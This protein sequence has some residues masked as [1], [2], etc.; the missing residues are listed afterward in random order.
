MY[1]PAERKTTTNTLKTTR[2]YICQVGR[3]RA[4]LFFCSFL[5]LLLPIFAM[6]IYQMT[7]GNQDV[8]S[9]GEQENVTPEEFTVIIQTF[10]RDS[11]LD[12]LKRCL[13]V[14]RLQKILLVWNNVGQHPSKKLRDFL[15]NHRTRISFLDQKINSVQNRLQP[16]P[17]INTEAV[18]MLDDDI[19]LSVVD[20]SFAFTVWQEFPDQIVGFVPRKHVETTPGVYIYYQG[21]NPQD[22]YSMVL[23]GASFFHQR[24]LKLYQEQPKEILSLVDDHKNCDDIAMNFVVS[25]HLRKVWNDTRSSGIYV[26]PLHMVTLNLQA[27]CGFKGLHYRP[28][29]YK[30]RSACLNRFAQ[31]YGVMPLQFSN[32]IIKTPKKF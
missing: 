31:I 19:L 7:I 11:V 26:K 29:H 32:I 18:L 21:P 25:R 3:K 15:F 8:V 22:K 16:F 30:Q 27:S 13:A 23:I 4:C 28:D 6:N 14:P 2:I 20:I 10:K 5:V 12:V 17:E 24:Y 1:N 9:T